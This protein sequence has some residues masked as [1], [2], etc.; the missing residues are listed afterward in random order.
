V[1]APE[2]TSAHSHLPLEVATGGWVVR[3]VRTLLAVVLR[4]ARTFARCPEPI[5]HG[6]ILRFVASLRLPLWAVLLVTVIVARVSAEAAPTVMRPIYALL[7]PELAQAL[8]TWIVLMVPVGIP[9]V[10]FFGGLVAHIGVA[11]T[12][13][14]PRSIGTSMR[15]VG[16]AMAP[17][18]VVVGGLDLWLYTG[19]RDGLVY[20]IV[21]GAGVLVFLWSVGWALA[22][23]HSISVARGFLVALLPAVLVVAVT[24]GRATLELATIPG[25]PV[26]EAPYFVP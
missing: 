13:G 1:S 16:C 20:G 25:V 18:Y 9:L 10:Y 5:D 14:A 3:C 19:A 22:R 11:L 7:E 21:L 2:F 4:P 15:A 17:L 23:T 26:P 8:S 6:R 12:G 24:G